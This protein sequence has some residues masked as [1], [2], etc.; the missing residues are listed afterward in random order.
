MNA[1]AEKFIDDH[2]GIALIPDF[3]LI[4]GAAGG[5]KQLIQV[6]A[7]PLHRQAPEFSG[8]AP[9]EQAVSPWL[10]RMIYLMGMHGKPLPGKFFR[11]VKDPVLLAA[12]LPGIF[13]QHRTP[14]LMQS[15]FLFMVIQDQIPGLT[16]R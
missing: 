7:S 6:M 12:R 5:Y 10:L 9:D 16:T 4:H 1:G 13:D 15:T 2:R 8:S 14:I 3:D 11:V